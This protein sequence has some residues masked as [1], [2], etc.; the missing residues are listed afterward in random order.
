MPNEIELFD[1]PAASGSAFGTLC[2]FSDADASQTLN[3]CAV[4]N[5]VKVH[6]LCCI[7]CPLIDVVVAEEPGCLSYCFDC[8]AMLGVT[9]HKTLLS[10]ESSAAL[11]KYYR[12]ID[13]TQPQLQNSRTIAALMVFPYRNG[14]ILNIWDHGS[15][16]VCHV[17]DREKDNAGTALLACSFCNVVLHNSDACLGSRGAP[18]L[19]ERETQTEELDWAC[20][21]CWKSAITKTKGDS[22]QIVGAKRARNGR[23]GGRGRGGR[24]RGR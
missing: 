5:C 21:R 12:Q 14:N 16:E 19:S 17:C 18:L 7:E 3:N 4:C 13:W 11:R 24:A 1:K 15:D 22:T 2:K 20:P 10:P 23:G 8:A 9:K 6:H